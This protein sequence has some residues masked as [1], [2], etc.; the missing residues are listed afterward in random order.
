[1]Q[2]EW[3]QDRPQMQRKW[4][5]DGQKLHENVLKILQKIRL[6]NGQKQLK[7]I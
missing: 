5:E 1:M 4:I 7:W 3:I 2:L 6:K